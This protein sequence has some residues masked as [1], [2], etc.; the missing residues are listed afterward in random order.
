[1]GFFGLALPVLSMRRCRG[2]LVPGTL[3]AF[4]FLTGMW[5]IETM[6]GA[7]E[8]LLAWNSFLC[9]CQ[10]KATLNFR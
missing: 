7:L 3:I 6:D 2:K 1:M 9:R 4:F 10:E 8:W 5:L